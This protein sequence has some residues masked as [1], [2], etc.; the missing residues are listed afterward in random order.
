M[1]AARE[2]AQRIFTD[3]DGRLNGAELQQLLEAEG[4]VLSERSCFGL[5]RELRGQP[6][7]PTAPAGG[8]GQRH[9]DQP[10]PV[11]PPVPAEVGTG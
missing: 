1:Q 3:R 10:R 5:L 2:A 8:N 7:S 11:E 6:V 4:H 9:P